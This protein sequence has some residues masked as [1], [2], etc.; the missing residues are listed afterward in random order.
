MQAISSVLDVLCFLGVLRPVGVLR[1]P[2]AR[3]FLG[4]E[5]LLS[6]LHTLTGEMLSWW[7]P[8]LGE[9]S[10]EWRED[11]GDIKGLSTEERSVCCSLSLVSEVA[12]D[13]GLPTDP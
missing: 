2:D 4:E 3:A 13:P 12:L 5:E 11:I 9:R 8:G 6:E 7:I 1:P 10:E